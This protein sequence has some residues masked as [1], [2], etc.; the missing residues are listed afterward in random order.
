MPFHFKNA[1]LRG[2]LALIFVAHTGPSSAAGF[3]LS[4]ITIDLP[5]TQKVATL[6]VR[7]DDDEPQPGQIRILRWTQKDGV[8]RLE[9]TKAVGASPPAFKAA[10]GRPL[11]VRI[12]RVATEPV[13]GEECYR[14]LV[15][16]VTAAT[17]EQAVSFQIRQSLPL[18]FGAANL[19]PAKAAWTLRVSPDGTVLAGVNSGQKRL[20]ASEVIITARDGAEATLGRAVVLGQSNMSWPVQVASGAFK[21]G[22]AV[23]VKYRISGREVVDSGVVSAK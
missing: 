3:Q 22:S 20:N 21:P 18:C 5:D 9:P 15:D 17:K 8:E 13:V 14:V 23:T 1:P 4:P 19:A 7:S 11:T 16:Q 12:V 2:A 6:E 10:K